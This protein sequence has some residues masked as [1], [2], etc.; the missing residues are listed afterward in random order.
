MGRRCQGSISGFEHESLSMIVRMRARGALRPRS[1]GRQAS[2]PGMRGHPLHHPEENRK[3]RRCQAEAI[4][5]CARR[6]LAPFGEQPEPED[7]SRGMKGFGPGPAPAGRLWLCLRRRAE[8]PQQAE[9]LRE[10]GKNIHLQRCG[11]GLGMISEDIG[12]GESP[13]GAPC[14]AVFRSNSQGFSQ[15][16]SAM[17]AEVSA[18]LP[19]ERRACARI[20]TR[21][22][23]TIEQKAI[24]LRCGVE[25]D[26]D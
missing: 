8:F 24:V 12:A 20:R 22:P 10:R 17:F 11:G 18:V 21:H 25:P 1:P 6:S 13:G 3:Q 19:G 23:R 5:H 7:D 15:S 2:G 26:G 16:H 9:F 14:P 4:R